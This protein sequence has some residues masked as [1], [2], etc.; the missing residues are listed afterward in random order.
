MR[1]LI[2]WHSPSGPVPNTATE[3]PER[4]AACNPSTAMRLVDAVRHR[5][6][7]GDDRDLVGQVLGHA[8]DRCARQQVHVLRPA[9]E[10]VR[11]GPQWRLLP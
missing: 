9:A 4:D 11:R 10:Q 8:E 3:N 5:H 6:H 2:R 7:F 1:L